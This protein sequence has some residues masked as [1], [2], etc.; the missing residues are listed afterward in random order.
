M[1]EKILKTKEKEE[2]I[3]VNKEEENINEEMIL[4]DDEHNDNII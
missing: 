1:Q 4:Q 3:K 2:I